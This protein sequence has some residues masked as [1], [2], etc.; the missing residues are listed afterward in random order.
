M[1]FFQKTILKKYQAM[2][3]KEQVSEA[4]NN[5]RIYFQIQLP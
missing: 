1:V 4:W 5:Y 2:L 3:P